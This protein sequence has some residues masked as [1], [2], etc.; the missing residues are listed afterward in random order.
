MR[1]QPA[2][3]L[4]S[5]GSYTVMIT[6][7]CA[8][9]SAWRDLD[10]TRWR[11]DATRDCWGQFYYVRD[12][13]DES[14]WSIGIQPLPKAADECAFEFHPDR[15][16]FRRW[17]GDVETRCVVC[18]VPNADAEV[19]AVTLINH[20]CRPR[21]FE[22]TS[23]TEV[24]LNDRRADQAHPAFAKLFLE[25]EFDPRC[26][27]LLARRR[28]RG[29]EE[30][31]VWAIHASA[32][33]VSVT[34][35][36]YETDRMRFLGRGRTPAN[37]AALD[38]GSR[39]SRTTGPVLDPIFSLRRRVGVEA[40]M[41]TRIAFVTGA[42]HTY[43]VAI[44][45]AERFREFEAIDQAFAGAKAHSQRELRELGLKPDEIALLNRLA[46]AVIFTNSSFRDLDAV[47]ANRLG[48]PGLWPHSI[49][50]DL[51]IVLVRVAGVDDETV[52]R[53]L[54]QWRIYTRR[55]GLKLD[56]V[57]LD[58][59]GGEPSDQLRKELETGVA[60]E[61]LG[62]AGGVFFLTA[63]KVPNDEAVL[64][65]A[66]ARAVLGGDRGSLTEQI[67]HRGAL[68]AVPAPPFTQTAIATKPVAQPARP[69]EGLSF[70]NGFG[71]F[72]RDGREY[73][74]VIDGTSHGGPTL[75]PAPWANVLA[76]PRFGCL[77]TEAGLGYSWAGNSQMNRL[78]P[79]SNDPTSDSPGE[80]IYLRDEETGDFWTPTPLPL[81]PAV[82]MTVR[83][84]QGYTRYTHDSR[85]LYQD[86]LVF[87]AT[88]DPIKLV[89]ARSAFYQSGGAY[90]ASVI[91]VVIAAQGSRA[92]PARPDSLKSVEL[93][94][95]PLSDG[96]V[97]L[98]DD[99]KT[100]N[101]RVRLG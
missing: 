11:E 71:G 22:L 81:G 74:I 80:V 27:A 46:A 55:R 34:E 72:T 91:S 85:N 42:A 39:L 26:G 95:Q 83:H 5:N 51:P 101:V 6:A 97:P 4:L 76:N 32:A 49:S 44:G 13:S 30:H 17:D 23:Y 19:R 57:I 7:A 9:Y 65:A 93:D 52:V 96:N 63:D 75:P 100:H 89:W 59:R 87:V 38:S 8:G 58:E 16:E 37:P 66:A 62:K 60:G 2:V 20:G 21:E 67:D 47:A 50:G 73:V 35:I 99:G 92:G 86:L 64:L 69:P 15:A 45:I 25:T 68:R 98:G 54:L 33:S 41:A 24:C 12:L 3:A 84:G 18:V 28:P 88:D 82:M 70:W 43:E 56:L 31:P 79:W 29:A 40:G 77:V 90:G 94:G 1:S 53:Q 61:M 78:T 36:E 14:L 10:I 48:Q